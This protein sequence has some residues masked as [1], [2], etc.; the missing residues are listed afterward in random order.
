MFAS[1]VLKRFN[2]SGEIGSLFRCAAA[3]ATYFFNKAMKREDP[4]KLREDPSNSQTCEGRPQS[5]QLFRSVVRASLWKAQC[6][7]VEWSDKRIHTVSASRKVGG[8][9]KCSSFLNMY[10]IL[11]TYM[12]CLHMCVNYMHA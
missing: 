10:F 9:L 7:A 8:P 5:H 12:Y 2:L 1:P 3:A 4:E 11:C 6:S